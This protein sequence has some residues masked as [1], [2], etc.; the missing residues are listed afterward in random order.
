M[1]NRPPKPIGEE[2]RLP[3]PVYILALLV[4][5]MGLAMTII[6]MRRTEP[7]YR[8]LAKNCLLV[9]FVEPFILLATVLIVLSLLK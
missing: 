3:L 2:R 9:A 8:R 1:E 5:L 7:E 4:P 6:Y